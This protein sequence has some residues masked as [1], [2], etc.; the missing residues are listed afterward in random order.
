MYKAKP[1]ATVGRKATDLPVRPCRQ[2]GRLLSQTRG[3]PG[4]ESRGSAFGGWPGRLRRFQ[5]K[6]EQ[7]AKPGATLG[8]KATDPL[9]GGQPGYLENLI[10]KEYQ[11]KRKS[12]FAALCIIG[13]LMIP[14]SGLAKMNA[15]NDDQLGEVVGQAGIAFDVNNLGIDMTMDT[16]YWGDSDGLGGN[17][18]GGYISLC[19]VT[20]LAS[21][22]FH[23]PMTMDIVTQQ[24]P[25]GTEISSL[26]IHLSDMTVDIPEFTIGAI[27]IGSAPGEGPSLGSFGI[28]D[29]H[30]NITGNVSISVRP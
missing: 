4:T 30:A 23:E 1:Q 13:L 28:Y 20:L 29:M 8:R 16:L 17:T 15:L 5:Q 6:Y 12:L 26:N 3:N 2:P 18:K 19:D 10:R 27:R 7:K 24:T 11:M 21:I 9:L 14:H 22:D 25:L